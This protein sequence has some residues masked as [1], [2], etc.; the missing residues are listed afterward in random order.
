MIEAVLGRA[1]MLAGVMGASACQYA[2]GTFHCER[3]EQCRIGDTV[4]LCELDGGCSF[5]D[6][7]CPSGWRYDPIAAVNAGECTLPLDI[8]HVAPADEATFTGTA[9]LT[10]DGIVVIDTLAMTIDPPLPEGA[11]FRAVAQEL[12]GPELA[13]LEVRRLTS[14]AMIQVVGTRPLVIAARAEIY[15]DGDLD[16][17]AHGSVA[18]PSGSASGLGQGVGVGGVTGANNLDS[19]GG[20]AGF[21]EAGGDG[22]TAMN[23]A[24]TALP[25]ARGATYGEASLPVLLGGSGGGPSAA[26]CRLGGAGGGAVQLTTG[27]LLE[28]SGSVRAGGGGGAGGNGALPGCSPTYSGGAGGGS[29]GAIYVQ[30]PRI[31]GGGVLAANG[32]GGGGGTFDLMS[33]GGPAGDDATGLGVAAGGVYTGGIVGGYTNGG[34]GGAGGAAG[35]PAATAPTIVDTNANAGGG[36]GGVGRIFVDVPDTEIIELQSSPMY[37]RR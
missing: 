13:L 19:G 22:G 7:T 11:T 16:V 34:V 27:L 2:T 29:G 26:P 14:T 9:D 25:G 5:D 4:G 35:V 1:V 28:I 33:S 18:G 21:G 23:G 20:G 36:G 12:A 31:G 6:A 30:A 17:S 24:A 3:D 15:L 10:W 8:A 32:G 37:T